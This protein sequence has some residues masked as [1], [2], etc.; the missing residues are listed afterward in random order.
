MAARGTVGLLLD[1]CPDFS[2]LLGAAA[3]SDAVIVGLNLTRR[4]GQL[5]RRT[6]LASD[7]RS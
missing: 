7:C 1:N 6:V 4:G 3:L 2:F 5:A